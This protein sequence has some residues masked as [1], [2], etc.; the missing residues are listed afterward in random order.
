[1]VKGFV[2]S[3]FYCL[4]E[5]RLDVAWRKWNMPKHIGII[6]DGNRRW[7]RESGLNNVCKGHER[8]ADKLEEVLDW[9]YELGIKTVTVWVFSTDNKSRSDDEVSGLMELF[10]QKAKEFVVNPKVHAKEMKIRF[11]GRL[12]ELPGSVQTAIKE[13][14]AATEKYDKFQL[15]IAIAY[16]GREEIIDGVRDYLKEECIDKKQSLEE[17]LN[18][19]SPDDIHSH[20]YMG[21]LEDPELII[22]TSGEIRL[23]GFLLWQSAYSEYYFCETFW[24][25]FRRIDFLRAIR[26]YSTRQRRFGR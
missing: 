15:N 23:S 22:R 18:Q 6:L 14:E 5:K 7:A 2:K 12:N 1:M 4:Y 17:T 19:L 24:P 21:D 26:S 25:A 10:E 16:G 3:P 8:G 11:I 9:C 20:L 13:A